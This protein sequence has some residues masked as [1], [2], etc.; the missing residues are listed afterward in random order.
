MRTLTPLILMALICWMTSG[1]AVLTKKAQSNL[2]ETDAQ[3]RNR[4]NTEKAAI[5][6]M[7]MGNGLVIPSTLFSPD[8]NGTGSVF[9]DTG[10]LTDPETGLVQ[11][12]ETA[13]GRKGFFQVNSLSL[14]QTN[15][16]RDFFTG[17]D[18][19]EV[20]FGIN[21]AIQS[22][23]WGAQN[24][25]PGLPMR[26]GVTFYAKKV[27]AASAGGLS[28]DGI[29]AHS[30]GRTAEKTAAGNALA[31][32]VAAEWAGKKAALEGLPV[33]I[34]QFGKTVTGILT[35]LDPMA[36]SVKAIAQ[37]IRNE[38][39]EPEVHKVSLESIMA[40]PK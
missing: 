10:Y 13:D 2:S 24:E 26:G 20:A 21:S 40:A 33:I 28:V 8:G 38:G 14:V 15:F 9:Q 11:T 5:A 12:M 39:A 23:T 27:G 7:Q 19:E 22:P 36:N 30:A 3:A 18:A 4:A 16:S 29:K 35:S 37:V 17:L 25:R 34:D 32:S 1:C 6:S 31:A